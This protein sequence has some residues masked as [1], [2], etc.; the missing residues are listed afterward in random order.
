MELQKLQV[1]A[2]LLQL[3]VWALLR[4]QVQRQ[5][6]ALLARQLPAYNYFRVEFETQKDSFC[7]LLSLEGAYVVSWFPDKYGIS[8]YG[9]YCGAKY[10]SKFDSS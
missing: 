7:A 1:W 8:K 10:S 4:G 6:R 5:V 9:P 2:L 3:Q